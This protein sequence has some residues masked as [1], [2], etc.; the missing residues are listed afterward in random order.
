M[1]NKE[2]W[3]QILL[4]LITEKSSSD[5]VML[6]AIAAYFEA[7]NPRVFSFCISF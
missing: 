2:E 5:L 7:M 6:V 3:R 1:P 4:K